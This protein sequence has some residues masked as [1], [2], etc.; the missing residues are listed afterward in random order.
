MSVVLFKEIT[1]NNDKKIA[2]A[3][4]NS[5]KSLNALSLEMMRLLI[6]QLTRWQE[7]DDVVMVILQGAG[8]K[9]F[10]A[11]GDVVSLYHLLTE[12][13]TAVQSSE[14]L[15]V[16]DESTIRDSLA[17][18]FFTKEYYLDQYIHEYTKPIMVWGDGYVIGGGIGLF[19][20]ASHRVVTENTLLAMPEITIGLYPDVGASWFLN[21]APSNIGLFL[22]LT[23]AMFNAADAKYIGLADV[24]VNSSDQQAILARLIALPWQQN[25]TN[26]VLLSAVLTEFADNANTEVVSDVKLNEA[27]ISTLMSYDNC[28]DIIQAISQVSFDNKWLQSAQKKLNNGSPLSAALIYRQLSSSKNFTL[29]ECFASEL[30][31]SLRCCQY[32]EFA[33]GV[34]ALLVDK[35]KAPNWQFKNI[36]NVAQDTVDWFFTPFTS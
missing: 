12:Q 4:L 14:A 13:R 16:L 24:L 7:D 27:A 33:E 22:G 18:E 29:A 21:K 25:E 1:T 30:N 36:N 28:A 2:V 23:G 15:V 11:G 31:L 10:C 3:E 34:R 19:A 20:G 17:Y 8:D 5:P 35:D 32:P 6:T 9:A 26:S